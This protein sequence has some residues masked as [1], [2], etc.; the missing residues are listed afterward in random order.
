MP[1]RFSVSQN[2]HIRL[3]TRNLDKRLDFVAGGAKKNT[4]RSSDSSAV[5]TYSL[6][7]RLLPYVS[8]YV[9]I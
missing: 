8:P 5:A 6:G 3:Q 9:E 2:T 7:G 4:F 1:Y